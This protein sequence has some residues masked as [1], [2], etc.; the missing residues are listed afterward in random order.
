MIAHVLY[1]GN[2]F[3]KKRGDLK[4]IVWSFALSAAAAVCCNGQVDYLTA[5]YGM[6][7]TSSNMQETILTAANVNSSSFGKLFTVPVDAAVYA[8]PLLVTQFSVPG[9][10]LR[11]LVIVATLGNTVYA[12]DADNPAQTAPYW[13]VN[14][15]TPF[16]TG[17]YFLGPTLGILSTPTIDR[18]TDTIYL[19]AII[20]NNGD[21]GQYLFALDLG[22][23]RPK[24]N[25]PQRITFT[26]S[27]GELNQDAS[28]YWL[29]RA[30]LLLLNN[31]LYV[32]TANVTG[33]PYYAFSE[34]G[35]VQAF[36]A[37]DMS[38]RLASWEVTPTGTNG[39][40]W[41]G[42]RGLAADAAGNIYVATADGYW[43][44][45]TDFG[46]SVVKL[47]PVS[48]SSTLSV[49]SYFTPA[50]WSYLFNNNL[51]LGANGVMLIPN[52]DFAIAGG[53]EGVVYLVRQSNPGGL[54]AGSGS[55][56]VQSFRASYGCGEADCSQN[57]ATAYWPHATNPYLYVWDR[58]D[59]LRAYPFDPVS[60][61]F[62]A[63]ANIVGPVAADRAGGVVVTSNGSTPG[64]GVLWAY[65][66]SQNAFE[67]V[68]PG[69]LR[70]YNAANISQELYNSDQNAARDVAGSFVKYVSPVVAN[71][72][73]YLGTHSG[74]LDVYGLLCQVNQNG[75][76]AVTRGPF[77]TAP[78]TTQF[79]QQLVVKNQGTTGIG[80]PFSIA[81][82]GLPSGISLVGASGNT[83]CTNPAGS[84][85][86]T[87]PSAPLWLQPGQSFTVTVT[88]NRTGS[89]GIT[90]SQLILAGSGGQ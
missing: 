71:G 57:L 53:K 28:A 27:T 59:Y 21:T 73:I 13:Q 20:S 58:V 33:L 89:A 90:Y 24:F 67:N 31:V 69:T 17:S 22:T 75:N 34:H 79:T 50:D 85:F 45:T 72:R 35:F 87:V 70:A 42:G 77:R 18:A 66:S 6:S 12:Y 74:T 3:S 83:A 80:G 68:V 1:L 52:S 60:Q 46:N 84:P 19:T 2:I 81:F 55:P 32:G 64:S 62:N 14:L 9:V 54:Q 8:L 15:G 86:V 38:V 30:G 26:M 37:S 4:P 56:P 16:Y 61:T 49:Q 7:R 44:G 63:T 51:D 11:D 39:G 48:I 5:Q 78:G 41:Q 25:S 88:F 82:G 43:N 47:S 40:V 76:V 29:Q 65:T 36:Q 23:G 10:G